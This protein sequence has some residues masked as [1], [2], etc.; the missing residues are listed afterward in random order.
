VS[1]SLFPDRRLA[2]F[3]FDMDGT[4]LNSIRVVERVWRDWGRRQGIEVEHYLPHLHGVRT[5]EAMRNLGHPG[6]DAE[7]EA[8]AILQAEMDDVEG[9]EP[10][11][12]VAAWIAALPAGRWT[13]VTS[14][15][16]ELALRRL[17]AVGLPVPAHMVTAEDVQRGKPAPDCFLLAA[18]R[19]G[20]DIADCLVFEDAPAGIAAAEAAGAAVLVID[21]THTHPMAT[22]HPQVSGYDRLAFRPGADGRWEVDRA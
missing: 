22:P 4:L 7:R 16:R 15:S 11:A 2:A 20:V 5:V 1:Q 6:L 3:L 14:A 19:L 8:A 9:I 12:G 13:V 18:R 17:A 21:A 10:I